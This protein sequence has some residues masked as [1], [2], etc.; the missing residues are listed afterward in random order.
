MYPSILKETFIIWGVVF[1]IMYLYIYVSFNIKRG[2]YY[3]G[4]SGNY[5][6]LYIHLYL[7]ILKEAFIIWG[8]VFGDVFLFIPNLHDVLNKMNTYHFCCCR[9]LGDKYERRIF[10]C[11][12]VGNF[13]RCAFIYPQSCTIF[14]CAKKKKTQRQTDKQF[15][16]N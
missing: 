11:S 6:Y 14:I 12:R 10:L 4:D 13:W 7:S 15:K 8:V 16:L 2:F 3:L 1:G 9:S 5:V